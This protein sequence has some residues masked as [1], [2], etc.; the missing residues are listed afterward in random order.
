MIFIYSEKGW[1]VMRQVV[2]T[3]QN[4]PHNMSFG[5]GAFDHLTL[6]LLYR[7]FFW[8]REYSQGSERI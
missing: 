1:V 4:K 3:S 7:F 5:P 6:M 8:N 2:T